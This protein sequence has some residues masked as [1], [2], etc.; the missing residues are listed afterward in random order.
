MEVRDL[1]PES[2]KAVEVMKDGWII[3]MLEKLELR[4]YQSAKKIVVVTDSFKVNLI[5]RGVDPFK[6]EVIKNGVHIE[7]TLIE[8]NSNR[9]KHEL[10]LSCKFVVAYIG[11][12][13]MAHGLDFILRCAP[14]LP[15]D[16]HLLFIGDGA[17]K[18]RLQELKRSMAL[19][20]ATFLP[21]VPKSNIAQYIKLSDVALVNLKKSD[22]FKTVLPSKIF[23]NAALQIPILL[24]V[25]GEAKALIEGYAAGLCFEP[26]NEEDFL[27]KLEM[28][29]SNKNL[30]KS[31]QQGCLK[32]AQD[33]D[34][35]KLAEKMYKVIEGTV[36]MEKYN[37]RY[38]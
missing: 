22:T 8:G 3:R 28:L 23:E 19:E 6:I 14:R 13:G 31:L 15:D 10:N 20:N 33:F 1:W 26:E 18:Q 7:N 30:Y 36:T 32:L 17:E 25:E 38:E 37:M 11:T 24:G 12:H 35:K 21:P 2:I 9:L 34:R 4:L 27:S 29:C 5:N 16:V